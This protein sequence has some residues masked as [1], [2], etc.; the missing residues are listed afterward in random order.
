MVLLSKPSRGTWNDSYPTDMTAG[1]GDWI[2]SLL[3]RTW[4]FTPLSI[5]ITT[6]LGSNNAAPLP[7]AATPSMWNGSRAPDSSQHIK[8]FA[9]PVPHTDNVLLLGAEYAFDR[10]ALPPLRHA[11]AVHA[12]LGLSGGGDAPDAL[13]VGPEKD[14]AA[15]MFGY[16]PPYGAFF[17]H[18]RLMKPRPEGS[19]GGGGVDVV[20][21]A[22]GPAW[23]SCRFY[24]SRAK[25]AQGNPGDSAV[26][27]GECFLR[28]VEFATA[29]RKDIFGAEVGVVLL[30]IEDV[31]VTKPRVQGSGQRPE[32][33]PLVRCVVL[34]DFR[35]GRLR[36]GSDVLVGGGIFLG[37]GD[38]TFNGIP[39]TASVESVLGK[40][41]MIYM[42]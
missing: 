2:A 7:F 14:A 27:T 10:M 34:T 42:Y 29:F 28:R 20:D 6:Q 18:V 12:A 5:F 39:Q 19:G 38:F 33:V 16:P 40:G 4:A 35:A 32:R 1:N 8:S 11:S 31:V 37:I 36:N 13:V 26:K 15:R 17:Y 41:W 9:Q 21:V 24:A 22:Q 25:P 3:T 23:T 30:P